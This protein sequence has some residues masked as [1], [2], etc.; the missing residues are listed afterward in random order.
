MH[1]CTATN[2]FS[3][4]TSRAVRSATN[5]SESRGRTD[6]MRATAS[7]TAPILAARTT[8]STTA[9][10]QHAL[11]AEGFDR[12][13]VKVLEDGA[14]AAPAER[15]AVA[16]ENRLS[17]TEYAVGQPWRGLV[18]QDEVDSGSGSL[19]ERRR[20]QPQGLERHFGAR[21]RADGEIDV[22]V[23]SRRPARP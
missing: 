17:V 15:G 14:S 5:A 7:R 6:W 10:P 19:F 21:P 9:R 2:R 23:V 4:T 22:T 8:L 18:E 13:K 1:S 12:L 3:A 16:D 11:G 20:E